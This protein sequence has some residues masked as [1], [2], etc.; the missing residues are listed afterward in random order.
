MKNISYGHS[1][2]FNTFFCYL[3]G[4]N[5]IHPSCNVFWHKSYAE[6]L[7]EVESLGPDKP[8][9]MLEMSTFYIWYCF[10]IYIYIYIIY[11]I[12]ILYIYMYIYIYIYNLY[13]YFDSLRI[14]Y[15]LIWAKS[16]KIVCVPN[17][18]A[19]IY[20]TSKSFFISSQ[21]FLF[22][23]SSQTHWKQGLSKYSDWSSRLWKSFNPLS[24]DPKMAKHIQSIAGDLLQ[25]VWPLC[26][27]GA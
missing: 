4:D 8:L 10:Y 2:P 22:T 20:T 6:I 14:F 12:Y 3:Q 26:G 21:T 5:Q 23:L 9:L 11:N 25:C 1:I 27:V 7:S 16:A 19:N 17:V 24:A 15:G 18:F 13:L